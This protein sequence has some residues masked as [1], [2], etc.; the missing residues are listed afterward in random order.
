MIRSIARSFQTFLL[1]HGIELRKAPAHQVAQVPVFQIAV[2]LLMQLRP[3]PIRFVQVGANDGVYG[4]PLRPYILRYGW[5]GVL[6]EPQPDVY[7]ALVA[8][9]RECADRLI[10]ENIAVSPDDPQVTIFRVPGME[11]SA[12]CAMDHSLTI[13][14]TNS[15]VVAAQARVSES[16]LERIVIP[17]LTLDALI[18]RHQCSDLDILQVDCEGY[19]ARVLESIDLVR[20][21]PRLIQFEHGHLKRSDLS[22]LEERLA[23]KEYR[24]LYGGKFADSLALSNE[25]L[26]MLR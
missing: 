22:V 19:D 11:A 16:M 3:E 5:R 1:S 12:G 10:F 25:F 20:H 23:R 26:A 2:N 7:A 18:E 4:D 17:A 6:V 21:R 15:S 8:N 9:Y 14:S 13:S 24:L